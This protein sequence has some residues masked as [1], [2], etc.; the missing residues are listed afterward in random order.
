MSATNRRCGW[1]EIRTWKTVCRS[2]LL[3]M[4]VSTCSRHQPLVDA[5]ISSVRKRE[6]QDDV[7]IRRARQARRD[8]SIWCALV[9]FTMLDTAWF[10]QLSEPFTRSSILGIICCQNILP[11]VDKTVLCFYFILHTSTLT[12]KLEEGCAFYI[13]TD[14]HIHIAEIKNQRSIEIVSILF[15]IFISHVHLHF[16]IC[17][18]HVERQSMLSIVKVLVLYSTVS[19]ETFLLW[20]YTVYFFS[21]ASCF[22]LFF[23]S[24]FD[25][26]VCNIHKPRLLTFSRFFIF[27]RY[28]VYLFHM[29]LL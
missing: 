15:H 10:A 22:F 17:L 1:H 5:N 13:D 12:L 21:S 23:F 3:R 6:L 27:T 26:I 20:I 16:V 7:C 8:S 25:G 28:F 14:T 24:I 29:I 11:C 9:L 4:Y 18:F 2:W 19:I